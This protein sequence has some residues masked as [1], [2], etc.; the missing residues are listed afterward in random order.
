MLNLHTQHLVL[1]ILNPEDILVIRTELGQT[2]E[3]CGLASILKSKHTN[4]N[5]I[6]VVSQ[7]I[8]YSVTKNVILVNEL[9]WLLQFG[10]LLST[11]GVSPDDGLADCGGLGPLAVLSLFEDD[12]RYVRTIRTILR[13]GDIAFHKS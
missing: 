9:E 13:R 11:A 8:R 6:S 3:N 7:E 5:K 12:V 1:K 4:Y 10:D 2:V